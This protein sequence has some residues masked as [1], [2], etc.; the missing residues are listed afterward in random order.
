MESAACD[1]A[2]SFPDVARPGWSWSKLSGYRLDPAHAPGLGATLL[3]EIIWG[4]LLLPF[5]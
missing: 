5:G 2:V 3:A 4:P 1:D